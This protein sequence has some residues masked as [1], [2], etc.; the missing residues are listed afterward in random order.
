LAFTYLPLS[1]HTTIDTRSIPE[2]AGAL[3]VAGVK[4]Y[5]QQNKLIG[6][7]K[8]FV[9]IVSGANMDFDRL[10][11]VAERADLGEQREALLSVIVPEKP[12]RLV[13]PSSPTH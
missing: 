6:S 12:G 5:V 7:G 3:A 8:R 10:R 11:F 4:R 13:N 2:P 1:P 9:S